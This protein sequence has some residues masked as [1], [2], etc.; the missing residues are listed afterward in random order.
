MHEREHRTDSA[1][2][3][4]GSRTASPRTGCRAT[5]R[6][7]RSSRACR[8]MTELPPTLATESDFEEFAG[9]LRSVPEGA[10]VNQAAAHRGRR[11]PAGAV[12][13]GHGWPSCRCSAPATSSPSSSSPGWRIAPTRRC[14]A[15]SGSW[16]GRAK[17]MAS[18]VEGDRPVR[19]DHHRQGRRRSRRLQEQLHGAALRPQPA[20]DAMILALKQMQIMPGGTP[21]G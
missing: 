17:K 5:A 1:S 11:L 13:G 2:S 7:S 6:R 9:A 19:K 12:A 10:E 14:P 16:R 3:T 8:R 20:R 15:R 18:P 21:H 4:T